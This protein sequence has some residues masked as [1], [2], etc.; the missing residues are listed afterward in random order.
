MIIVFLTGFSYGGVA[1]LVERGSHKPYVRGSIPCTAI[2]YKALIYKAGCLQTS[3]DKGFEPFY[4]LCQ[5]SDRGGHGK[6]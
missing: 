4:R 2:I 5:Q 1:Q 3:M 6:Q